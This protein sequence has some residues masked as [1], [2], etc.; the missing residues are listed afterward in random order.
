MR[1]HVSDGSALLSSCAGLC[2]LSA[3]S[4]YAHQITSEFFDPLFVAQ[5]WGKKTQQ[6]SFTRIQKKRFLSCGCLQVWTGSRPVY[7][8]GRFDSLHPRRLH[9]LLLHCR[10]FYEKVFVRKIEL[11]VHWNLHLTVCSVSLKPQTDQ[12]YLQRCCLTLSHLLPPQRSG[13][14]GEPET[15][16]RVQ[17][18]LQDTAFW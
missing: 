15:P 9:A 1:S 17:R 4:L 8:L 3:C 13:Q 16:P 5:K 6:H 18:L 2:S 14:G 12:L 10:R 11:F 7:R